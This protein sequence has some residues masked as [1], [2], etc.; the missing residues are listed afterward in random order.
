MC[1]VASLLQYTFFTILCDFNEIQVDLFMTDL[2][3]VSVDPGCGGQRLT[4]PAHVLG[5]HQYNMLF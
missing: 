1:V 3:P 5:R 2:D 4:A